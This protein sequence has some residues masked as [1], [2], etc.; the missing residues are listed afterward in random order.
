MTDNTYTHL[1]L[2]IDRS[3]SMAYIAKDMNGGVETLLN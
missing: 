2:V 1:A 3:G